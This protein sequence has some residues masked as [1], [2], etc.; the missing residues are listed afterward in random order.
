MNCIDSSEQKQN[1]HGDT[2]N[3]EAS[4]SHR[5]VSD[6]DLNTDA[7][8]TPSPSLACAAASAGTVHEK[9]RGEID[10]VLSA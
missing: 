7:H 2:E 10:G 1:D 5:I 9:W 6:P 3:T 8:L 4:V